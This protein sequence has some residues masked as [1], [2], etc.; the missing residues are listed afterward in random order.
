MEYIPFDLFLRP[1]PIH[2]LEQVHRLVFR[3][4]LSWMMSCIR[5]QKP[6]LHRKMLKKQAICNIPE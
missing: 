3:Q 4:K 5:D 6:I 1:K 2:P